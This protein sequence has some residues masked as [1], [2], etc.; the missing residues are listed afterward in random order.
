MATQHP[1]FIV[2][3]DQ[4]TTGHAGIFCCRLRGAKIEVMKAGAASFVKY[5]C[6][7][8]LLATTVFHGK[9]TAVL[10][11]VRLLNAVIMCC[12]SVITFKVRL[13]NHYSTR[14]RYAGKLIIVLRHFLRIESTRNVFISLYDDSHLAGYTSDHHFSGSSGENSHNYIE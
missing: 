1:G 4:P 12:V 7:A 5:V 9:M 14:R 6:K 3:I 10:F 13:H 11:S 8:V 2:T